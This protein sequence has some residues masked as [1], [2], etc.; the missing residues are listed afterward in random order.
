MSDPVRLDLYSDPHC[1]YAYL[2]V[3]RLR[4]LLPAYRGRVEIA[5]RALSLE[6]VN[7]QPTPKPILDAESPTLMLEEP[8]IPYQPWAAP[9]SEWPVT[10][11]PAFEAV[12]CAARQG[13]D[14]AWALDWAIRVAFFGES[15]CVS[16]RHVLFDVA[17]GVGVNMARFA[18]DFDGGAARRSVLDESRR[19]WE[20]LKLPGSPTLVLPDGDHRA[21]HDLGLP[22]V[23]LDQER[24]F[25]P[26]AVEPAPCRGD[27]CLDLLRGILDAAA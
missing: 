17:E 19:G 25:R 9:E 15:R 8:D 18:D 6:Y 20:G 10:F 2:T 21:D 14:L 1:P 16:M 5:H 24:T 11:W 23:E 26:V 3:F 7:Q 13:N 12:A 22:K 4:Q 27:G